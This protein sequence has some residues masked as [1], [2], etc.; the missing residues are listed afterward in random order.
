VIYVKSHRRYKS[1]VHCKLRILVRSRWW[2]WAFYL[3]RL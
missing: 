3:Q 2:N 1:Q